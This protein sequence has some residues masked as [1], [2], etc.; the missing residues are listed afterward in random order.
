MEIVVECEKE[1]AVVMGFDFFTVSDNYWRHFN[2]RL[3]LLATIS[4]MSD[5]FV[6][7]IFHFP[8]IFSSWRQIQTYWRHFWTTF[9]LL[10]TKRL[11]KTP[12][13]GDIFL[14]G[15]ICHYRRTPRSSKSRLFSS[16]CF[17]N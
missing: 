5:N 6:G 14:I 13:I 17:K 16:E 9:L 4:V 7:K 12:T 3:E 10:A 11:E 8:E 15:D 1:R 2:H